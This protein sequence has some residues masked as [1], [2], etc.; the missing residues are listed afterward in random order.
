MEGVMK[1][2]EVVMVRLASDP[3]FRTQFRE[4]PNSVMA[5]Y[6]LTESER[7]LLVRCRPLLALTPQALQARWETDSTPEGPIWWDS[8]SPQHT[9]GV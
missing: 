9:Y 3:D 7:R 2:I 8:M 5:E 1:A 4:D 6:R